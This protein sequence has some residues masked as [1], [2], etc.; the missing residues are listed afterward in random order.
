MN[1]LQACYQILVEIFPN[2]KELVDSMQNYFNDEEMCRYV[3]E[4]VL[5]DMDDDEIH[6]TYRAAGY[7]LIEWYKELC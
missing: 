6:R 4:G 1:A 3:R 5:A 7:A 2:S